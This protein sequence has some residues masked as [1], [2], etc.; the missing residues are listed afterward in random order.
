MAKKNENFILKI[1]VVK[2]TNEL[3]VF[4]FVLLGKYAIDS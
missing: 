4:P 1:I 3:Q 2:H